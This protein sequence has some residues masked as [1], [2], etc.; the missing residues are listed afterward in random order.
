MWFFALLKF[1]KL[2]IY[3]LNLFAIDFNFEYK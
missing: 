1:I 2:Y 3:F